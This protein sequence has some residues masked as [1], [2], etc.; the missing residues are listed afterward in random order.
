MT[1]DDRVVGGVVGG[2]VGRVVG[3]WRYPVSSLAGEAVTDLAIGTMG[4]N[5]DRRL[6][7]FDLDTMEP[8]APE[9]TER[10]RKALFLAAR[11]T[12]RGTPDIGF[13]DGT[14]MPA[15]TQDLPE[16]LSAHFGFPVAL[17]VDPE[18]DDP[19]WP[20]C[21][22]RY[23]GSPLHLL[24]TG[25][26]GHLQAQNETVTVD[27]RRFR[28]NILIET[29][30]TGTFVE[31]AW[32]GTSL[33]IGGVTMSVSEGTKRCGMTMIAQPGLAEEPEVLRNIL[34]HNRRHLGVYATVATA[35]TVMIGDDVRIED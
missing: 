16:T 2:V 8:A 25:S 11:H 13:P 33:R 21:P 7:L 29:A 17:G 3:L 24:T 27:V 20:A 1:L 22:P 26:L 10:W 31:N 14:W 35:G 34:R 6:T 5:G 12:S 9:T 15:D 18:Q 4:P 30:E 28:P 23:A 19:R 32:I